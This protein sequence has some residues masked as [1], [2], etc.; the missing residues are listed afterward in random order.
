[1]SKE[2]FENDPIDLSALPPAESPHFVPIQR[3]YAK[4]L[5]VSNLIF[6]LMLLLPILVFG[7]LRFGLLHWLTYT[8]LIAWFLALMGMLFFSSVSVKYKSFALRQ[9]DISYQ[10]GVFFKKWITIPFSRVQHC[11]ISKG[12]LDRAFGVA[13]LKVFTAGGSSSDISIPGLDPEDAERVKEQIIEKIR[14]RY[15]EEE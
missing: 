14:D 11:E 15:D 3:A 13:E 7:L 2:L 10:T 1:M 8:L 4:V 6:F 9:R 5:Y 12:V